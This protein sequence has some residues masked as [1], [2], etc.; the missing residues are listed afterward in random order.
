MKKIILITS[1]IS[2]ML[3]GQVFAQATTDSSTWE[4]YYEGDVKPGSD[5][6]TPSTNATASCHPGDPQAPE[7]VLWVSTYGTTTAAYWDK[8]VSLNIATGASPTAVTGPGITLEWK[9][10]MV[11]YETGTGLEYPLGCLFSPTV[12]GSGASYSMAAGLT[13]SHAGKLYNM[14]E[15]PDTTDDYHVY[16]LTMDEVG[17]KFFVDGQ[18]ATA[19]NASNNYTIDAP[20]S[21][22]LFGDPAG[23]VS[24]EYLLDYLRWTDAGAFL[25]VVED[26]GPVFLPGDA[27]GDGVVSAGDYASVQ[28]HF[29][30]TAS[31]AGAATPEPATMVLLGI[32][33]LNLLRR[34]SRR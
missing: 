33:G 28:A 30:E 14:Y 31:T 25:P 34:K 23:N 22:I 16:R 19:G 15:V 29:G 1:I 27:N 11:N 8:D 3:V 32:G 6:W 13:D 18:L 10:K 21:S 9:V 17:Y 20:G 5:G 2:F 7:G 12:D 24:T 26:T 4:G